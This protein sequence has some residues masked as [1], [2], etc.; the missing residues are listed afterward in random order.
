M[1][2]TVIEVQELEK[3]IDIVYMGAQL[4]THI[5]HKAT[6]RNGTQIS[7]QA[8]EDPTF[9]IFDDGKIRFN[10]PVKIVDDGK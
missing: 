1:K 5:T 3:E 4:H 9:M 7:L 10:R 8:I 2:T 6:L